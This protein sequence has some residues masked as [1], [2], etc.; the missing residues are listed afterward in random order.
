MT[1]QLWVCEKMLAFSLIPALKS[2]AFMMSGS[3]LMKGGAQSMTPYGVAHFSFRV[4]S[5]CRAC[6]GVAAPL[7]TAHTCVFM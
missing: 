2:V 3:A 6:A 7:S 5:A 1:P 4:C